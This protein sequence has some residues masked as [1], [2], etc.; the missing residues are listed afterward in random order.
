MADD[1]DDQ[2]N[3][4]GLRRM[5]SLPKRKKTINPFPPL[6]HDTSRTDV[7]T[8]STQ[9]LMNT[10]SWSSSLAPKSYYPVFNNLQDS[11]FNKEIDT[12]QVEPSDLERRINDLSFSDSR[13]ELAEGETDYADHLQQPGNN[14][15][16]KVPVTAH[17]RPDAE[18]PGS[19][20]E[21]E[22]FSDR[23]FLP[24]RRDMGYE[25]MSPGS[26]IPLASRSGRIS[27]AT[28]AALQLKELL[29]SRKHQLANVLGSLS[30]GDTFALD[31]ALSSNYYT[32]SK[33][34]QDQSGGAADQP[35]IRLSRRPIRRWVREARAIP[36]ID[37]DS[38][39]RF[40]ERPFTF[41]CISASEF[42]AIIFS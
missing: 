35:P 40:P 14:K 34:S 41:K 19:P 3:A 20:G 22:D 5:R 12:F 8:T 36:D 37:R 18:K 33:I 16:R 13:D 26:P 25:N 2:S 23:L 29:K 39:I 21:E 27:R 42:H 4:G 32:F 1:D 10:F 30:G 31:Q 15:K 38:S 17:S 28:H 24:D 11:V 9:K 6:F 7:I